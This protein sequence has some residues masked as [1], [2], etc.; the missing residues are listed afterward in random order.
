MSEGGPPSRHGYLIRSY[1]NGYSESLVTINSVDST[2]EMLG[3]FSPR[4][5][6]YDCEMQEETTP[7]G[8]FARGSYS[9]RSKVSNPSTVDLTTV[10]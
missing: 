5:E 9:A 10:F 7:S 4:V 8:I 2:K 3:T 6:P 1:F